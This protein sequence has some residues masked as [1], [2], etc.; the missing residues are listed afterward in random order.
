ML[1][2]FELERST[3]E[4]VSDVCRLSEM[5]AEDFLAVAESTPEMAASF[6]N[7][8]RKRLF[9]KAV[10]AYSLSKKRGLTDDDLVKAFHESDADGS[11]SLNLDEVR[12]LMHRMDPNFP[13]EEIVA[14]L[15]FVDV[16]EDGQVSFEEFRRLFR[17]FEEQ[18]EE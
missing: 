6:R 9:K 13:I 14:L 11:G 2:Y 4:C 18:K 3:V 10:K 12:Q 15:K 5:Q 17:Q 7:I 1:D 16:D 8:C